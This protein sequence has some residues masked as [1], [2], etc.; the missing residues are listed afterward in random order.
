MRK[1]TLLSSALVLLTLTLLAPVSRAQ[2]KSATEAS[3][4]K[5]RP[6]L[7]AG[8]KAMGGLEALQ[9]I[10]DISREMAGTRNDEGQ[11]MN[12]VFPRVPAPPQTN[13]PRVKSV[14]DMRGQRTYD[15][16]DDVIFGG[17]PLK[18]RSALAGTTAWSVNDLSKNIRVVPPTAIN[19]LRTSRFRR[20]PESLLLTAW[21]R[22]EALRWIGP[23][24]FEGHK[25]QVISLADSDGAQ[26]SLYFDARTS[27]LSKTEFL[28]DD[29][30]LGDVIL[31]TVYSDWRPVEKVTLPFRI[32]DRIGG[33]M[34][35]DLRATSISI[36]AKVPDGLFV[37]PEGYAKVEPPPPGPN[38]KK[39]ADDV[40]TVLGG[41][42]SLVVIFKDYVLVVEAGGNN[43]SSQSAIAEIK[44]LAPDKPI[45]YLVSTHFHFDHLGG[46]RSYVA[47]GTTIVTTPTS[48]A[49]IE[50]AAAATHS[51]RPD[52]L[53]KNPKAP[54]FEILDS[55]KRDFDDGVR[56]V[57]LYKFAS[58][59][60]AEIIVAYLPKEKILFEGDLLDI[61]EAGIPPAG[62]D[63][64][65][66]AAQIQKLGL[67]VET[68]VPVHGRVGTIEDLR[69]A[70]SNRKQ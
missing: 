66:L 30:V 36:N 11:G 15:E 68:I 38:V 56:R 50:R 6:V 48:R 60:V 14:R 20:Y 57:E 2:Q 39:L 41:Y 44:K 21:N 58:P 19:N 22:P 29:P 33:V 69:V 42:N 1:P 65:D 43:R 18:L 24:E 63:T 26:V 32:T 17:Q 70:L 54:L 45:R 61:P 62:D 25:Q 55:N 9:A 12:P 31:E 16:F 49:V 27:L 53:S 7:E 64:V 13:R 46:V 47:E 23:A 51:M 3:F 8:I 37:M 4:E 67:Q 5:A 28:N 59:H 40:Y 35:Q 52:S 10:A 34:Q